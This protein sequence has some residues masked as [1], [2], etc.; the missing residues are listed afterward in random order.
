[1]HDKKPS[2]KKEYIIFSKK[3]ETPHIQ[4]KLEARKLASIN[5]ASTNLAAIFIV[6]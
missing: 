6:L 2:S 4:T 1:L 5:I 3:Q